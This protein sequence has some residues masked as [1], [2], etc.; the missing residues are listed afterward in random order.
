MKLTKTLK[1]FKNNIIG[2]FSKE[3][4]FK[5]TDITF[6]LV[7]LNTSVNYNVS[8]K[9][10]NIYLPIQFTGDSRDSYYFKLLLNNPI[11]NKD[12]IISLYIP[13]YKSNSVMFSGVHF[14]IKFNNSEFNCVTFGEHLQE[15]R[16]YKIDIKNKEILSIKDIGKLTMII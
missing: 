6:K 11:Q 15:T 2:Y 12:K 13:A 9:D 3:A 10:N 1:D 5:I 16:L 7:P 8:T 4:L 14:C